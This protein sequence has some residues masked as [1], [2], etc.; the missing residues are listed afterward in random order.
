VQI[1]QIVGLTKTENQFGSEKLSGK[2]Y[3]NFNLLA[4]LCLK[5]IEPVL[6]YIRCLTPQSSAKR[7]EQLPQLPDQELGWHLA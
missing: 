7:L 3:F 1:V 5:P 6:A 2:L 4:T